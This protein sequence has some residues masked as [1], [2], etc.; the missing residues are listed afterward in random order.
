MLQLAH[1]SAAQCCDGL[2]DSGACGTSL[3]GH[4]IYT[5]TRMTVTYPSLVVSAAMNNPGFHAF[6]EVLVVVCVMAILVE[7][8]MV[9]HRHQLW[10]RAALP[11]LTA[12]AVPLVIAWAVIVV[13][14]F[15]DLAGI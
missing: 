13:Q 4:R 10:S 3:H 2:S 14:R 8:E 7:R 12:L 5:M 15:V 6:A 1:G 11:G 9:R